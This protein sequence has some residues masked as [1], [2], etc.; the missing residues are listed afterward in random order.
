MLPKDFDPWN[1]VY[2]YFWRWRREGRWSRR[3]EQLRH[4]ER[5]RQ[6]R[7]PE[8]SAGSIDSQS[9]KTGTQGSDAGFDRN[10][11]VKGRKRHLLVDT[12]GLIVA[13]GGTAGHTPRRVGGGGGFA[14]VF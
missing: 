3:M 5:R 11:R 7:A 9:I 6:G 14:R 10:K 8:P 13:G 4:A 2:G 1:T 12:L